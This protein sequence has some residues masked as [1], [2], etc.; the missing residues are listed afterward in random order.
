MFKGLTIGETTSIL[1]FKYQLLLVPAEANIRI[2]TSYSVAYS[3]DGQGL[4][5]YLLAL[6]Q[7]NLRPNRQCNP[8]FNM[9]CM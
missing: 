9:L 2:T 1:L 4:E 5:L 6:L 8:T 7:L 3:V